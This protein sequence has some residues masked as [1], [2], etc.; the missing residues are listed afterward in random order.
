M[1]VNITEEQIALINQAVN[2]LR[3]SG[4]D[5]AA[6]KINFAF[7]LARTSHIQFNL[8]NF[9]VQPNDKIEIY[10]AFSEG[11]Y[12]YSFTSDEHNRRSFLWRTTRYDLAQENKINVHA[13]TYEEFMEK[14]DNKST[15]VKKADPLK[16][17]YFLLLR[18]SL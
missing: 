7:Q 6:E 17:A 3:M 2:N 10:F 4:Q 9:F 12:M 15:T 5:R 18:P 8:D 16:M 11:N 14:T 1:L 13:M